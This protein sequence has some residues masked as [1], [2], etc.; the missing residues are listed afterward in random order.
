M[1]TFSA[2]LREHVEAYV[3]LRRTLGYS[4]AK[5]AAI[6]RELVAYIDAQQHDGPLS[7]HAVLAFIFSRE[8]TANG[9]AVRYGV[10]RRIQRVSRDLRSAHRSAR[11]ESVSQEQGDSATAAPY[12]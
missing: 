4:L 8:S 10:V 2:R 3:A 11:P 12:R 6:L 1:S 7:L 9:R 5:Q